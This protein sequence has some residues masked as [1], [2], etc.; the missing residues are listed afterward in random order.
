[1]S[2]WTEH[3]WYKNIWRSHVCRVYLQF[4]QY[5]S[6]RVE[7]MC[8]QSHTLMHTPEYIYCVYIATYINV[9]SN[10]HFLGEINE[11]RFGCFSLQVRAAHTIVLKTKRKHYSR[12]WACSQ[13]VNT[14]KWP[15][16]FFYIE[17]VIWFFLCI[18]RN[19]VTS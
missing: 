16:F 12:P 11:N 5:S 1:M 2:E 9:S 3:V 8:T 18:L 14:S 17:N 10:I 19:C 7:N 4:L 15:R 6:M 13:L